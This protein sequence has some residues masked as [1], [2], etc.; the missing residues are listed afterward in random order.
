MVTA[1]AG[2]VDPVR[3]TESTA[4][5]SRTRASVLP[6]I[7]ILM[8]DSALLSWQ[9]KQ[10]SVRNTNMSWSHSD[11]TCCL[12]RYCMIILWV[13]RGP[14]GTFTICSHI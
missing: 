5:V 8:C 9:K 4:A 1:V 13:L 14:R 2:M 6:I 10:C 7:I 12:D 11:H 3:V